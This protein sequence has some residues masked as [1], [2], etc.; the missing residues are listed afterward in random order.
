MF[1][2]FEGLDGSGSSTQSALLTKYF[3]SLDE[4]VLATKE[5]TTGIIGKLVRSYL[6]HEYSTSQRALQLLFAAD[7]ED[8]LHRLVRPSLEAQ[9]IVISDRYLHSS[10]AFGALGEG[11]KE[12]F[13][14]LQNLYKNFMQPD[15]IFLLK[16]P[17]DE[18]IKRI[19][20]RGG[21]IELF[22]KKEFLE[23]VWKNYV[24]L[25]KIHSHIKI[26]DG[27]QSIENVHKQVLSYLDI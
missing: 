8:H 23:E 17:V 16:V 6:Q 22:E 11:Q 7:R 19:Q 3:E 15:I 25:A 1:I 2:V 27:A 5:P 9:T 13:E 14:Y 21:K 10:I 18:C 20:Q 24:L 26:I 12:S 4:K